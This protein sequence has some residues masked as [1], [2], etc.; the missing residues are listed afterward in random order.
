MINDVHIISEMYNT[1]REQQLAPKPN[2]LQMS[3]NQNTTG[4]NKMT[5]N[6]GQPAPQIQP[7]VQ[8]AVNQPTPATTSPALKATKE[9]EKAVNDL[10]KAFG[11]PPDMSSTL[12]QTLLQGVPSLKAQYGLK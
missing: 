7:S 12:L 4:I 5:Q 1:I 2:T 3:P 9:Q 10:L 11:L 8:T 6:T